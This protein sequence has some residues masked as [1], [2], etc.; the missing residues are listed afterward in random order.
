MSCLTSSSNRYVLA[1][2][3]EMLDSPSATV[4][5]CITSCPA[6]RVRRR[7]AAFAQITD[8]STRNIASE[9]VVYQA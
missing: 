1:A 9:R 5:G 3:L 7:G 6:G 4:L 8:T 2:C